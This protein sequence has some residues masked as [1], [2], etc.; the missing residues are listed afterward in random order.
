[1]ADISHHTLWPFSIYCCQSIEIWSAYLVKRDFRF[2]V[3]IV[4][5]W[6]NGDA[7][8]ASWGYSSRKKDSYYHALQRT[9]TLLFQ[10]RVRRAQCA[11]SKKVTKNRH[12]WFNIVWVERLLY[13]TNLSFPGWS[14]WQKALRFDAPESSKS[15]HHLG[16]G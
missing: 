7:M 5:V 6:I 13:C 1:M 8:F 12:F 10:M 15:T 16:S 9:K 3:F 2:E 14:D 4:P 11:C